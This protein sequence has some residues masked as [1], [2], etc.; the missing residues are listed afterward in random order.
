MTN[1]LC[2]F[3]CCC[4]SK[5]SSSQISAWNQANLCLNNGFNVFYLMNLMIYKPSII[6]IDF[7]IS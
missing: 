3:N 4:D 7:S 5:C 1:G 2:D 6:T